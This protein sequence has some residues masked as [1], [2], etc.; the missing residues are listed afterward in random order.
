[1]RIIL[2]PETCLTKIPQRLS[3]ELNRIDQAFIAPGRTSTVNPLQGCY[4]IILHTFTLNIAIVVKFREIVT[5]KSQS[6]PELNFYDQLYKY[7]QYFL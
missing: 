5:L 7:Y 2:C 6:R 4:Y 1:M 3:L